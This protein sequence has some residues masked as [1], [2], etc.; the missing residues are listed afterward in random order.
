[1][2][3]D[4]PRAEHVGES[5][6]CTAA[7][8]V[9][10]AID[11]KCDVQRRYLSENLGCRRSVTEGLDWVFSHVEDAIVLEDDCLPD[12]SFFR[13][14]TELLERYRGDNRIGMISGGNFQF[15]QNQP[16]DSYYF[17]RHCHI[18]G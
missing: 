5:E 10:E 12:P 14:S 8:N 13:F 11:W 2:I 6:S 18:W 16:A 7:R 3:A 9:T 17:S 1:M 15:G 4:G